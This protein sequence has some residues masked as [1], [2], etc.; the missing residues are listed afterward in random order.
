M[1]FRH[2]EGLTGKN[3]CVWRNFPVLLKA[4]HVR[5]PPCRL[6][7][8]MR[9]TAGIQCMLVMWGTVQRTLT[10]PLRGRYY[11]QRLYSSGTMEAE[12]L[13]NLLQVQ[14]VGSWEGMKPP[15]CALASMSNPHCPWKERLQLPGFWT[16]GC[17][18]CS[19]HLP[20]SFFVLSANIW[21]GENSSGCFRA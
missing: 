6:L 15:Y 9:R 17:R 21:Q 1:S 16:A 18:V 19:A 5:N 13:N 7:L 11:Y 3:L 2:Q 14:Q 10:S 20:P 8:I 12:S 4:H